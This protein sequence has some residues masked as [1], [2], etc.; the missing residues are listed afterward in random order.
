MAGIS[1]GNREGSRKRSCSESDSDKISGLSFGPDSP[2][3]RNPDLDIHPDHI[4][5]RSNPNLHS[6]EDLYI[7]TPVGGGRGTR[8]QLKRLGGFNIKHERALKEC[9][10]L[11]NEVEKWI[12]DT[13]ENDSL[14]LDTIYEGFLKFKKRIARVSQE[15]LIRLVD[16]KV[17]DQLAELQIRIESLRKRAEKQDRRKDQRIRNSDNLIEGTELTSSNDEVF[18]QSIPI[19]GQAREL[20]FFNLLY[21]FFNM[22]LLPT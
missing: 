21:N 13:N 5:Y 6:P 14:C 12:S 10:S 18:T 3:N 4:N 11:I 2:T 20:S 22:L 7:E 9:N 19:Q 15:A 8:L 16:R 1:E 17:V